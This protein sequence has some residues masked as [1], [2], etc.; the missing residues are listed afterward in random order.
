MSSHP[1]L[2]WLVDERGRSIF[3]RPTHRL[4]DQDASSLPRARRGFEEGGEEHVRRAG[5]E[6]RVDAGVARRGHSDGS[7]AGFAFGESSQS[8]LS[9]RNDS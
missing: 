6:A 1:Q 2:P 8:F 4:H 7:D 3:D 9:L 5:R